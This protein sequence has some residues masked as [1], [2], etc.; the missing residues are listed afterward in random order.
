MN[1]SDSD[2]ADYII[3]VALL[4]R[5]HKDACQQ[6]VVELAAE[7][8]KQAVNKYPDDL[9]TAVASDDKEL[10]EGSSIYRFEESKSTWAIF[11][12]AVVKNAIA[13]V[14]DIRKSPITIYILLKRE[15]HKEIRRYWFWIVTFFR[16][17]ALGAVI[18]TPLF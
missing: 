14:E 6:N 15:F 11:C 1:I 7:A 12:D 9:C 13:D 17:I 4:L 3:E 5:D 18:G 8:K 16:A 10:I 2:P